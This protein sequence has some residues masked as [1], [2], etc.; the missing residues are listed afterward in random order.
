MKSNCSIYQLS[1]LAAGLLTSL[2]L[3]AQTATWLAVDSDW[4][5]GANWDTGVPA[6]G[7]NAV[8]GAGFT[9]NY[10]TPMVAGAFG[11]LTTSSP[12]NVSAGGFTVGGSGNGAATFTTSAAALLSVNS[13]GVFNV[14]NG[15]LT[16]SVNGCVAVA[17]GGSL[18]VSGLLS[19]GASGNVGFLTN[20]GGNVSVGG[21]R[22]NP[23]NSSSSAR[24]VINGGSNYLGNVTIWRSGSGSA[25]FQAVGLEGFIISNGVVNLASVTVG[26]AAANSSL[27]MYVGG[28]TVT[29]TGAFIV[30]QVGGANS[31]PARYLQTGGLVVSTVAEGIRI[32]VSNSTQIAQFTV[33]G[34]TN[35]VEKLV[36]GDGSNTVAALTVSATN[37]AKIYIGSGGVVSNIVTTLN[38]ALN[39]GGTFGANADWAGNTSIILAGGAF[40]CADLGA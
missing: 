33:L 28:G 15:G 24:A 38:L 35:I 36:L 12:L 16:A 21:L 13:G 40:D 19:L 26:P 25:A 22:V 23:N 18:N 3:Q 2:T 8:I 27:S 5:N 20:N 7:T 39:T 32:G 6:E 10:S 17:A 4:N 37:A 14:T 1:L 30:G 34:G 9:V 29:N 31:R 11:T